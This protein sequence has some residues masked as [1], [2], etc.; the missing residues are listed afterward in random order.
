MDPTRFDRLAVTLG[1]ATTRRTAL[2]GLLAGALA[3][4]IPDATDAKNRRKRK[5]RNRGGD[6]E[7]NQPD[8]PCFPGESCAW[9]QGA[10]LTDCDFHGPSDLSDTDCSG[11]IL[12][13]ANLS[14][15]NLTGADL[16][17]ANLNGA[18]IVDADL[19]GANMQGVTAEHAIFCR[20]RMPDGSTNNSGCDHG[21][22]CCQTAAHGRRRRWRWG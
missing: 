21:T 5:R 1:G 12:K 22:R 17:G 20:T 19:S 3:A 10:T 14:G 15:A 11:C 4:A 2:A 16:G 6:G 18:C 13:G 7:P 8:G 9:G